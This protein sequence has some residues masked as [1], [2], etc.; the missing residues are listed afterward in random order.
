MALRGAAYQTCPHLRLISREIPPCLQNPQ[1]PPGA[2]SSRLR[3]PQ[4]PP[5]SAC[6]LAPGHSH[7][8][9][10]S[11]QACSAKALNNGEPAPAGLTR[12]EKAAFESLNYLYKKGGGYAAMMVTRPQTLGY[13]LEDSPVG[14]AAFFHD[15][16]NEWTFS[17]GDADKALTRDEMLDD[18]TLYWVTKTATSSAQLH[19]ENNANNCNAVDISIPAAVTVFPGEI[20]RAPRSWVERS[21]RNLIYFNEVDKG[22]HFAAWEQPELFSAE[23]RAAFRSLR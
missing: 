13:A 15:K 21:Y 2:A 17:G 6:S 1:R 18:I 16:F 4:A 22:G 7:R 19:W 5:A 12:K 14:L 10:V 8:Q 9:R 11:R 3:R 23:I 20:Y